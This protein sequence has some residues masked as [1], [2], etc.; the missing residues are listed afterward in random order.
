MDR[1]FYSLSKLNYKKLV[2]SDDYSCSDMEIAFA[3]LRSELPQDYFKFLCECPNTGIFESEVAC[4]GALPAP[5]AP[6]NIY[7]ISVLY[8]RCSD[9]VYDLMQVRL[10]QYEMPMSDLIIGCDDAGNNFTV[11]LSSH[12]FGKVYFFFS[13]EG[14]EEGRYLVAESFTLFVDSLISYAE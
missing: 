11:D 4:V 7:P 13:E 3:S 5:C 12:N 14:Y 8:A 10:N 2:A 1:N 6:D 9:A